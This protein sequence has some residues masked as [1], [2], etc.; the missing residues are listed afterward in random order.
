MH[1]DSCLSLSDLFYFA[2]FHLF[3]LCRMAENQKTFRSS[4]VINSTN[5]HSL[6][7]RRPERL[8]T[9]NSRLC[10]VVSSSAGLH[11]WLSYH[12]KTSSRGWTPPRRRRR[13]CWHTSGHTVDRSSVEIQTLTSFTGTQIVDFGLTLVWLLRATLTDFSQTLSTVT[14]QHLKQLWLNLSLSFV[15]IMPFD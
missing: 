2:L 12:S 5:K 11:V 4:T 13:S 3:S 10:V 14:K 8:S 7:W 15:I 1:F 9:L 6:L